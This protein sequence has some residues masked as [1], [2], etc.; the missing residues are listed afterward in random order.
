MFKHVPIDRDHGIGSIRG[1][2]ALLHDSLIVLIPRNAAS[3][4][5]ARAFEACGDDRDRRAGAP[6]SVTL[7]CFIQTPACDRSSLPRWRLFALVGN[8]FI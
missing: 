6:G 1:A 3:G 2:T 8:T 5:D 4:D 7:I